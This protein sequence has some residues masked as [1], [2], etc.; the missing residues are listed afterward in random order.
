MRRRTLMS[1]VVALAV[2]STAA[3]ALARVQSDATPSPDAS[4][5]ATPVEGL[6]VVA[7]P[8]SVGDTLDRIEAAIEENDLTVIARVDHAENAQGADL[9]LLPTQLLIFGNP[10]LGTQLMQSQRTIGIDLPQKFLAWEDEGGQVSLAYNDPAYLAQRH[11][12]DDQDDVIQQVSQALAML[13]DGATA[14]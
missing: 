5:A 12:L 9:E 13:A 10:Q 7:S 1:G 4:P 3:P 6:V 8:H 2:S 11:G 14:S